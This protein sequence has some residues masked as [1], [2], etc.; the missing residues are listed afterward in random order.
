M[1]VNQ[2]SRVLLAYSQIQKIQKHDNELF[3]DA[4][5]VCYLTY[6]NRPTRWPRI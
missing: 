5:T 1:T 4:V 6:S 3:T 2:V